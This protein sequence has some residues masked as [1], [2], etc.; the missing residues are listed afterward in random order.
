MHLLGL[1]GGQPPRQVLVADRRRPVERDLLDQGTQAHFLLAGEAAESTPS[2]QLGRAA[3]HQ[4]ERLQHAV[5]DDAC[6]PLPL[7]RAGGRPLGQVP[8]RAVC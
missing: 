5:V 3:L 4:R 7:G 1:Q 8:S 6:Q 2:A